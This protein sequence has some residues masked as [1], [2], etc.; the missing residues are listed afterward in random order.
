ME[1]KD[2]DIWVK[3]SDQRI[4]MGIG[5]YHNRYTYTHL[6]TKCV[7]EFECHGPYP[8]PYKM[9]EKVRQLMELLIEDYIDEDCTI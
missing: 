6:P 5:G 1:L 8:Q 9:R 7:I 3:V 2:K 4:G